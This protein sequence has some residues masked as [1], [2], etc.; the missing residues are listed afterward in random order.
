MESILTHIL[1]YVA[2]FFIVL[3]VINALF[4]VLAVLLSWLAHR[5]G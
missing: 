5:L 4:V 3:L 2:N 1:G